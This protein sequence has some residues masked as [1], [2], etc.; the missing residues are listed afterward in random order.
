M[1]VYL[2]I[3]LFYI[4][5]GIGAAGI[6]MALAAP[7]IGMAAGIWPVS[8]GISVVFGVIEAP[9]IEAASTNKSVA[10]EQFLSHR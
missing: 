6:G 8:T 5:A 3:L 2:L 9:C 4:T 7:G 10:M 1:L